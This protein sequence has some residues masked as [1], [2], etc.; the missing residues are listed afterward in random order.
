[1]GPEIPTVQEALADLE[2]RLQE[3]RREQQQLLLTAPISGVVLPPPNRLQ[4][5]PAPGQLPQ[6]WGNPLE[7][8][9]LG[10]HLEAGTLFCL[11]GDS[12][13]L[14]AILVI[15]QSDMAFVRKG[16]RVRI[17]LDELPGSVLHGTITEIA[18]ADLKVLPRELATAKD[19]PTRID[20]LGVP[21]PAETA[22][23]ACVSLESHSHQLLAGACGRAKILA[24][25]QPL[26]RRLYRYLR[27][28]F[29]FEL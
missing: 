7:D 10:C 29:Q 11:A 12:A 15:D 26:A 18:K 13:R 9:N 27:R 16:Q 3:R 14:E 28:T 6:W 5:P 1:V 22:Y 24:D 20:K 2:K 21:R 19:L 25:P 8:R 4:G 23:H 17:R